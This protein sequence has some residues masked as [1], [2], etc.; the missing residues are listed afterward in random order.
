MATFVPRD[1]KEAAE[2]ERLMALY[3]KA[4]GID[5]PKPEQGGLPTGQVYQD[6][7]EDPFKNPLLWD[8]KDPLKPL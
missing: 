1:D 3:K 5:Q 8:P 7:F 4:V 2:Y 6:L